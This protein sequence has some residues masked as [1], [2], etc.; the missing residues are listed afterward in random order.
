M[1]FVLYTDAVGHCMHMLTAPRNYPNIADVRLY[2]GGVDKPSLCYV[3]LPT[4]FFCTWYSIVVSGVIKSSVHTARKSFDVT[5]GPFS[6][7]TVVMIIELD[8]Y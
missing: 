8:I 5:C 7:N 1:G 4:H 3:A 6:S 2:N